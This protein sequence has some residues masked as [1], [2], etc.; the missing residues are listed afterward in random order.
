MLERSAPVFRLLCLALA[1]L[2]IYQATRIAFP[3]E[4]SISSALVPITLAAPS[5]NAPSK[6]LP[7]EVAA[8]IEKIRQSEVLG[9]IVRP[10]PMALLGIAG[11]DVILR[12]PN[13]QTGLLRVG[14]ELGGVKLLKIGTNR[15]LIQ[16]ENKTNE[17]TLFAGFGSESLLSKETPK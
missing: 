17:L 10:L 13:G 2:L 14:E 5:T 8:R 16:F 1:G 11:P 3:R 9:Q 12:A 4:R 15:V 6:T 7:P